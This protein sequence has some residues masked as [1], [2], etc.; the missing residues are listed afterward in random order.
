[1]SIKALG[2]AIGWAILIECIAIM[3]GMV[4]FV[5]GGA[6]PCGEGSLIGRS[7]LLVALGLHFPSIFL[8]PHESA[9]GLWC[10]AIQPV[11]WTALLYSWFRRRERANQDA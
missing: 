6:P 3:L 5:L 1:M 9:A 10:A 2:N 4:G 8:V 7:F 11:I